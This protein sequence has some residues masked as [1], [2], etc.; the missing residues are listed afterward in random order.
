MVGAGMLCSLAFVRQVTS[1]PPVAIEVAHGWFSATSVHLAAGAALK[2]VN[3]DNAPYTIEIPGAYVGDVRLGGRLSVTIKIHLGGD[4]VARI[5]ELPDAEVRL[6]VDPDPNWPPSAPPFDRAKIDNRQPL[7][8]DGPVAAYGAITQFDLAVKGQAARQQLLAELY[9]LE[10]ELASPAPPANFELF[11]SPAEWKALRP[12]VAMVYGLGRSAYD[13]DRFGPEV[14]A[15][16]PAGLR[17]APPLADLGVPAADSGQRDVLVRVTS[18]S[19]WFNLRVCRLIWRRLG[20]RIDHRK[21]EWGYA[22]PNGRSPILGGF[23]DGTGN[24]G[25]DARPRA[26]FRTDGTAMLALFRIR[27]DEDAFLADTAVEQEEAIGRER[28]SGKTVRRP[29]LMA[30]RVRADDGRSDIVRLPLIFDEGTKG[31]GLLFL[32]AEYSFDT[33]E[34]LLTRMTAD[35]GGA[36]DRMLKY[37]RFE[38]AAYYAV[39]SSP[40]GGY[41]GMLVKP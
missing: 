10:E 26:E 3:R 6:H 20:A 32:V 37:M 1:P 36:K 13:A 16:R 4:F 18:D 33:L 19:A 9:R 12:S 23:Y 24:P 25:G 8:V 5:E 31:T 29:D 41:P 34:A 27:F 15:A 17:M 39:P 30:H 28:I 40:K 35:Q 38:S 14:A 2:L 22:G 7:D 11:F 21:L